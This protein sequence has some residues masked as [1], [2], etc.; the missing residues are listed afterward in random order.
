MRDGMQERIATFFVSKFCV[1]PKTSADR[2]C[3]SDCSREADVHRLWKLLT[4]G[5]PN[6]NAAMQS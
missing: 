6:M 2:I 5:G 4:L 1:D 3:T